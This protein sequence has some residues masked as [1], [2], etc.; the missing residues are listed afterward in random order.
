MTATGGI[1]ILGIGFNM[2]GNKIIRVGNLL[3]A[4]FFAILIT[5]AVDKL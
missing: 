3:P 5:M 2:L 4:V 1:L